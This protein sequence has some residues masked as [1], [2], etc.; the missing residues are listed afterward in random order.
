MVV[1]LVA[2]KEHLQVVVKVGRM[3]VSKA[4]KLAALTGKK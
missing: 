2:L 4:L 1:E 3:A